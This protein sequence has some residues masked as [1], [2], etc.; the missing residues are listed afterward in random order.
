MKV[1]S[2]RR[3][4]GVLLVLVVLAALAWA[5]AGALG[6]TASS[7][8]PEGKVVFTVGTT[9]DMYSVNLFVASNQSEWEALYMSYDYLVAFNPKDLT[10]APGLA[11]SWT[12][13]ADNTLWT[14]KIRDGVKFADGTPLTAR[15]IAF[16]YNFVMD[17]PPNSFASYL[18]RGAEP[19][20]TAPDD[21]TFVWATKRPTL[22]PMAPPLIWILPEHVWSKYD[23]ASVDELRGFR[24]VP[25]DGTGPFDLVEWKE[26]QFWRLEK[27]PDYWGGEPSIDEVVFKLY[28]NQ[29][30]MVQALKAG[31][32]DFAEGIKPAL[33]DTLRGLPNIATWQ[34]SAVAVDNLAFGLWQ[35]SLG[36]HYKGFHGETPTN[37]PAL[38][39]PVV[40]IAIAKAIDKQQL[41]EAVVGAGGMAADSPI[42]PQS[43][44]YWSPTAN[45]DNTQDFDPTAANMMLEQAGYKDTNGDGVRE[46]PKTGDPL[47]FTFLIMTDTAYSSDT[48]EFIKSF[49]KE[50][51]IDVELRA[52][53]QN[54]AT[55][56]WYAH[57]YDAYIWYWTG[58]PDPNF[59][60]SIFTTDECDNW[61]DG[62]YSNP[63]YDKLF[64]EQ[65]AAMTE[66]ARAQVV[67]QMQKIIYDDVPEVFLFYENDLQAYRSDRFTGFVASPEPRG[68]LL[69]SYGPFSYMTIHPVTAGETTTAASSSKGLSPLVWLGLVVLILAVVAAVWMIRRRRSDEDVA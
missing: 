66:E 31:E 17:N 7:P 13:N 11:E 37:H 65:R 68:S 3:T 67:D 12:H 35:P 41:A 63:E 64:L 57:D 1:G 52:V 14:F 38:L 60:L 56:L 30:A 10:P 47:R 5:P 69:F 48:G 49:L 25:T 29:E 33:F 15:D 8:A 43:R 55:D 36:K 45:G 40:R 23:G 4:F 59:M 24:N 21:R 39:D 44:W 28:G 26:G 54:K 53:T 22:A 58:D 19:T 61:S 51:G 16:T 20:F 50:I 62:C 18:D 27:N 32:I 46:D 9:E 42:L 6:Q 34:A 2:S